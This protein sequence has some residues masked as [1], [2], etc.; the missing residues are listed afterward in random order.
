MWM[1]ARALKTADDQYREYMPFAAA[2]LAKADGVGRVE[3]SAN[4]PFFRVP[5]FPGARTDRFAS[6]AVAPG[7]DR[8]RDDLVALVR[9]LRVGG[10]YWAAQPQLPPSYVLARS[11]GALRSCS[12]L[13]EDVPVI[14]WV[15]RSTAP[16][17]SPT[18]T[19]IPGDCDPWHMLAGA[20]AFVTEPT[21]E[22]RAIAAM[23]G[24]PTYLSHEASGQ[25]EKQGT[26]AGSVLAE[27]V[28]SGFAH[29]SPF[30]GHAMSIRETAELCGFWRRMIDSNR[31]IACGVGFAFW[32]QD[33]VAPLL[34]N[35]SKPF[36]F[37][38]TPPQ[39]IHGAVAIWRSKTPP[40]TISV[41]ERRGV[42]LVEV[43]DG[44]LRSKGL[45]AD[46]IPPLSVTVDRLGA[47]F[48]PAQA[49]EL[50]LL[51]ENASFDAELLARARQIRGLIVN[52]GLGKYERGRTELRRPAGSRRHILVPGQVEDD[53]SV[54]T[55]G[56]GML[57]I[58]LLRRVREQSPDAYIL[59]KPHPDVLAG[60]RSGSV[61]ERACLGFAD[62]IVT[63]PPI[64]ALIE[65]VDE[66]HVNTSLTGFEALMRDKPVTTY[67]AP[68][69]AGWGLTVDLG[70]VPSRRS[71]RRTV[72]EL[73]AATLLVYPRYRDPVT[74]L[75]C[76]AEIVVGRL[77]ADATDPPG[78]IV[79]M[80]RLQG[81]FMR[82]LRS[83][84]R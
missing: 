80:R 5:P 75:P 4:N 57:N 64:S 61:A 67:G 35:G 62:Q 8:G 51:L 70:A 46:C 84:A 15:E 10:T 45:G 58:E 6:V 33:N 41:L 31:E 59:F 19:V 27:F 9:D 13:P 76:P 26:D 40:E 79:A 2:G 16:A 21:D 1:T 12:E 36:A 74:G 63:E 52:A 83:V 65:M 39:T 66:I 68:F 29:L 72:D 43:E 56:S 78:L 37:V 30:D 44:F 48:D 54:Q 38:R 11:H 82:R 3:T 55:G 14:L 42:R 32:K 50:E 81:R 23:L 20:V 25:I 7:E 53:R 47:H 49:S 18:A 73:V 28:P 77:T 17:S 34:W 71:V 24:V 22:V 60:H 69:Y